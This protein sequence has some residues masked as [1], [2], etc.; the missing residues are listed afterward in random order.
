MPTLVDLACT[1]RP[2]Q[3]PSMKNGYE[4]AA[5][6][7]GNLYVGMCGGVC[8]AMQEYTGLCWAMNAKYGGQKSMSVSSLFSLNFLI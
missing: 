3:T 4:A 2:H 6:P 7:L 8:V 1:F 5:N